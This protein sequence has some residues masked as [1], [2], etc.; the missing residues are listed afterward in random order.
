MP[1]VNRVRQMKRRP[2]ILSLACAILFWPWAICTGYF[3][4][5]FT[6]GIFEDDTRLTAII[7]EWSIVAIMMSP[8][9]VGI[10]L[11]VC[12]IIW[13]RGR[14]WLAVVGLSLHAIDLILLWI[15]FKISL[16]V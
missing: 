9:I 3:I 1:I 13:H 2:D 5:E 6:T 7:F 12:S 8:L 11:A 16:S 10:V 4:F 14:L 15:F